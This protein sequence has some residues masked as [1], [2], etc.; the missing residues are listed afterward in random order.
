MIYYRDFSNVSGLDIEGSAVQ[1]GNVL[2]LTQDGVN[3]QAGE[4]F[5][6]EAV[7]ISSF[8]THFQWTA[9][10]SGTAADGV[11][12]VIRAALGPTGGDGASLGFTQL[13]HAIGIGFENFFPTVFSQSSD[14]SVYTAADMPEMADGHT[15]DIWIDYDGTTVNVR[16]ANDGIRPADA[17]ISFAADIPAIVGSHTAYVGF[18][19]STGTYS[20]TTNV[21]DWSFDDASTASHVIYGSTGADDLNGTGGNDVIYAG[22]SDDTVHAGDGNDVIVIG[23][24]QNTVDA[25]SGDDHIIA[26]IGINTI[27]GGD[28]NDSLDLTSWTGDWSIDLSDGSTI[29]GD[30]YTSIENVTTGVGNDTITGSDADNVISSGAGNDTLNGGDGNDTLSGG[31]GTNMLSGGAG[32]DTFIGDGN[33]NDTIDGGDGNDTVDYSNLAVGSTHYYNL[34]LGF[35][36]YLPDGGEG[37]DTLTSIENVVGSQDNDVITGTDGDNVLSGGAGNDTFIGGFGTDTTDGG[38][39]NDTIDY[40]AVLFGDTVYINLA[41]GFTGYSSTGGEGADSLVSIENVVG[42]QDNNVITGTDGDN[43]L[44][45][46]LGDDI[47][48]GGKGNDTLIGGDGTDHLSGGDGNDIIGDFEGGTSTHQDV[49]NGG[50]G[51]DLIDADAYEK[52]DGGDGNDRATIDFD[53]YSNNGGAGLNMSL[54]AAYNGGLLNLVTGGSVQHVESLTV[55]ATAKNDA[56]TDA[57]WDGHIYGGAGND[58][59][60][61][62]AGNDVLMGGTGNDHLQGGDGNDFMFGGQGADTIDGG[63]GD[64]VIGYVALYLNG[65]D[66]N[67]PAGA[68]NHLGDF[69]NLANDDMNDT[70]TDNLS[71][72]DGDDDL[73]GWGGNDILVGGAG[74]D[75]LDGGKGADDMTGGTGSDVYFVDNVGD[76]IHEDVNGGELDV[77]KSS[78]SYTL[79]ANLEILFLE[80]SDNLTGTGNAANNNIYGNSGANTLKG[81]DG[82]DFINGFGGADKLFGGAGNDTYVVFSADERVSE[83][84]VAGVDD[85]G[86]DL[87]EAWTS[88]HLTAGVENLTLLG[89]AQANYGA[90]NINAS[91]TGNELN[92]I[93]TGNFGNNTLN[94]GLGADTMIGGDGDDSYFVDNTG[95]V[96]TENAKEGTDRVFSTINYTLGANVENLVLSG[97]AVTGTG[98]GLDNSLTGTAGNN[99]LDGMAGNDLL[100]GGLGADRMLGGAG[101]DTYVIDDAGDR[102][103]E[104]HN[105]TSDDGGK[106]TVQSY[107]SF[108][109]GAFIENLA[110]IGGAMVNATG[111]SLNNV[112]TGNTNDNVLNG[113]VGDDTMSGGKGN[114]TYFVDSS[115]DVVIENANEGTKDKVVSSVAYTLTN[116][117]E[118]LTETGSGNITA[119]G[120]DLNNIIVA[121]SGNNL[122]DGQGGGDHMFGGAGNDTY[123]VDNDGDRVS[124]QLD[125]TH[126]DGG[127]DT[128]MANVTYHIFSFVENLTL[129]GTADINGTGNQFDNVLIGNSGK[130]VLN[131][132]I[133]ADTMKG[134]DGDDGYIVDNSHD[135]VVE[136]LNQG[137]DKVLASV[138]YT[139]TNNVEN[140]ALTGTGNISA[141]GNALNNVI[142]G[143]SG[144]NILT[145]GAGNDTLTG[146]AGQDTFK[147]TPGSGADVIRDFHSAEN[148][149]ITFIGFTSF[150]LTASGHDALI[151][152]DDGSTVL[153]LN[154]TVND[155]SAHMAFA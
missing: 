24:G 147:F 136:N 70:S 12:L 45:G 93:L 37:S 125:G 27:D 34:A 110:L 83:Q 71:G 100:T 82:D 4:G 126:D 61:G 143:N 29:Y 103:V 64:D 113:D 85:G 65:Y 22:Q 47:I 111:N 135:V 77:V 128:V 116:N 104:T 129:T 25:G 2:Q 13:D 15:W 39:G 98:N 28:G 130:N 73:F 90:D 54:A 78:I 119:T 11:A 18:T 88:Y 53:S 141:T 32:N 144:N 132:G 50:A 67:A 151:T 97:T 96:V 84:T 72:G 142:T 51:D 46:G 1:S 8:S 146:G 137:T 33:S 107:I 87:V 66:P 140:L 59:I 133:G 99:T 80:G 123:I 153:V 76:V 81:L 138:S 16:Y 48:D 154:A 118:N 134:G 139:L 31:S 49:L 55:W 63:A 101:D 155:V 20:S 91:L 127:V 42:S 114:D 60:N 36:S 10:S 89:T 102:A 69:E 6:T 40:S 95:D 92:N 117:V 57:A 17:Q 108:H 43:R 94:G 112:L 62:A 35:A 122:I 74:D 30:H 124:E 44:D 115:G 3:N 21:L 68:A 38:D 79:G 131:G 75:G 149:I 23:D 52:I 5:A 14:G 58:T 56:I 150:A 148:D 121:T 26:G 109:L 145:G 106:D 105:G 19:G 86:V 120:N 152:L 7:N 9:S 41:G